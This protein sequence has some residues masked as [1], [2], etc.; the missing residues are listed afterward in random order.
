MAKINFIPNDPKAIADMKMRQQTA[1]T[2]PAGRAGFRLPTPAPKEEPA[3]PGTAAFL[4]WQCREAALA[5]LEMWEA[6]D[7]PVTKWARSAS[8][9]I[10]NIEVDAGLD[11]NAYYDGKSLSFFHFPVGGRDMYSGASTDAVSHECGHALLDCIRPDLWDINFVEAAALHEAFGDC[12]AL[13]TALHDKAT[14]RRLLI[15]SPALTKKS[16]VE[17]LA[18]DLSAAVKASRG[19]THPAAE[20]RRALNKLKWALPSTLPKAG[21]PDVLSSEIHSFGR[22]FVGC[23]YDMIQLLFAEQATKD[24]ATLWKAAAIAGKLL[25]EGIK[26]APIEPRFFRSVGRAML[27]ADDHL[28]GGK[29]KALMR[30]A[31][32]QH[33]VALGSP[34]AIAPS[35]MLAGAAPK[36]KGKSLIVAADTIADLRL[37]VTGW[38]QPGLSTRSLNLGPGEVSEVVHVRP[39][40]LDS[41]SPDLRGAVAEGHEA[42]I[43]SESNQRAALIGNPPAESTTQDEVFTFVNLLLKFDRLSHGGTKSKAK[44]KTTKKGAVKKGAIEES[45]P[46]RL[47]THRLAAHGKKRVLERVRFA[48]G[49]GLPSLACV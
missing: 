28:N 7:G 32:D 26:N 33:N 41:L 47:P 34:A 35:A 19:P 5:A 18:E 11:L 20:P 15:V 8:P 22:V 42:V 38:S 30:K 37:R 16:F 12:V 17:A 49:C 24:Q 4:Y 40:S 3:A 44:G 29:N 6:I 46:A 10:L 13:L 25:I 45:K 1:R 43:V 48:C 21:P 2:R 36:K 27:I 39:I 14:R 31:F 23:F 9:K